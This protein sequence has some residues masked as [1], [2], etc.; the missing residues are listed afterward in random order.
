MLSNIMLFLLAQ[1][2]RWL[3]TCKESQD[4]ALLPQGRLTQGSGQRWRDPGGLKKPP[5]KLGLD[6]EAIRGLEAAKGQDGK[7]I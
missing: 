1:H 5:G 7:E 4:A 6:S 3:G 2:I